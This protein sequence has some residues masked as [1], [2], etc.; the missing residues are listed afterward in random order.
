MKTRVWQIAGVPTLAGVLGKFYAPPLMA[1]VRAALV[2]DRAAEG[3]NLYQAVNRCN[4]SPD[5]CVITFPAV[6][7]GKRL[8][9][10]QVSAL[11]S[12][13]EA[14]SLVSI[15]LRGASV[16]Q[17]LPLVASPGNFTNQFDYT[18]SGSVLASYDASQAPNVDAF[19]A[20]GNPFTVVASIS[21]Y[22]ID[23]P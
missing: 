11:A 23:I 10:K 4:H 6:P 18:A 8:I 2:Q 22:M 16:F 14:N 20:T 17:F 12:M 1:Q 21:G 7:A 9:V 3:R 15:Q 19:A 5:P 13:A